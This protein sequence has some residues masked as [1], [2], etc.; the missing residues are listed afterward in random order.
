MN[1]Q[2]IQRLT[3][4]W[5]KINACSY[6]RKIEAIIMILS[7]QPLISLRFSKMKGITPSKYRKCDT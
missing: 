2:F 1:G 7:R 6:L 4:D 5:T 3:I